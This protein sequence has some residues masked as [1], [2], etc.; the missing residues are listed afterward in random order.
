MAATASLLGHTCF[1]SIYLPLLALSTVYRHA[2]AWQPINWIACYMGMA[3]ASYFIG[4]KLLSTHRMPG[5]ATFLYFYEKEARLICAYSLFFTGTMLYHFLVFKPHIC[6]SRCDL[7]DVVFEIIAILNG[8]HVFLCA[9]MLSLFVWTF[10]SHRQTGWHAIL[11]LE[12]ALISHPIMQHHFMV[13]H[14]NVAPRDFIRYW[15]DKSESDIIASI[16]E[17]A[18][19][20]Y[21]AC[22]V[23]M[24]SDRDA[25][26]HKAEFFEF[27]ISYGIPDPEPLWHVCVGGSHGEYLTERSLRKIVYKLDFERRS[28]A[29]ML[30]TDSLVVRWSL[31][32]LA[33]AVYGLV[34][35]FIADA[36]GYRSAFGPGMDL[37]KIYVLVLSFFIGKMGPNLRFLFLMIKN[38]PFNIG[39]ILSFE[40]QP[41]AVRK[42]TTSSTTLVGGYDTIVPNKILI[43]QPIRNLSRGRVS[44]CF[45]IELPILFENYT[46]TVTDLLREYA[47]Y[48]DDVDEVSVRCG[49]VGVRD[50]NKVLECNWQYTD[51]VHDRSRYLWMRTHIVDYLL[52]R[53]NADVVRHALVFQVASGGGLNDQYKTEKSD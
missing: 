41:Y 3:H 31:T 12:E 32:Y 39:D 21:Q 15:M 48:S 20:I 14:Q 36:V 10:R 44:D 8:S 49:W 27:A 29:H 13:T 40:G 38:R 11:A 16:N 34:A 18:R 47:A 51:A 45:Q 22:L 26:V 43:D 37:L 4:Y 35:V 23:N 50:G 53:I 2:E 42:T 25:R 7:L 19:N 5:M 52:G 17:R 30:Y 6:S 33:A 28:F 9:T 46:Q 24:D 1:A